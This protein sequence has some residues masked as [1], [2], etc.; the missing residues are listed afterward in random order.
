MQTE[1]VD[2]RNRAEVAQTTKKTAADSIPRFVLCPRQFLDPWP[3]R[4]END[5]SASPP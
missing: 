5:T 3:R 1:E 2:A 4:R